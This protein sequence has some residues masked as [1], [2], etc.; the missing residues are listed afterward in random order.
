MGYRKQLSFRTECLNSM[1]PNKHYTL[2]YRQ[3]KGKQLE[4]IYLKSMQHRMTQ[5]KTPAEKRE[6]VA[7]VNPLFYVFGENR[8]VFKPYQTYEENY[9]LYI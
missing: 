9:D 5:A 8:K 2:G 3:R 6:I 1:N 4:E 7:E